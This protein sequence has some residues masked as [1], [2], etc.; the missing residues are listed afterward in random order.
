MTPAPDLPALARLVEPIARRAGLAVAEVY[1]RHAAPAAETKADGSP[2]TEADR[3]AE[4]ALQAGLRALDP[5]YLIVSEESRRLPY[6][7]RRAHEYAWVC[8]PLDGTK[9]FLRRNGEFCVCVALVADGQPVLGVIH[10]PVPARSHVAWR[11][12]A[13]VHVADDAEGPWRVLRKRV[14]L[15]RRAA[16]L[17]VCV[18]R[19]HLTAATEAFLADFDAPEAVAMGSALKFCAIADGTIDVYPRHAPTMEWDTAAGQCIVEV[20]GGSVTDAALAT[21]L[22]YNKPD[23][24]NP[25]FVAR[26]PFLDA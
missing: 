22:T 1:A 12:S 3:A 5:R 11:G 6:A 4:A 25:F 20:A 2:L 21:P 10:A 23:L 18:S 8:D 26:A 24:L 9:E 15:D 17:R 14:S 13:G 7:E 19:S 16:G